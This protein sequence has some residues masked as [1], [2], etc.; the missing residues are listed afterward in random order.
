MGL[1]ASTL[2]PVRLVAGFF[3]SQNVFVNTMHMHARFYIHGTTPEEDK[4]ASSYTATYGA[5]YGAQN[6]AQ[7]GARYGV[8]CNADADCRLCRL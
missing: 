4:H 8:D 1:P 5:Q 3:F 2:G 6:D 7:C